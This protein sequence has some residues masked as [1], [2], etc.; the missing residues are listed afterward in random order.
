LENKYYKSNPHFVKNINNKQ[1]SWTAK[2]YEYMNSMTIADLIK[3]A[4]G[5]KSKIL[6]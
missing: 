2:H 4:G 3:M 1:T 5:K 6:G